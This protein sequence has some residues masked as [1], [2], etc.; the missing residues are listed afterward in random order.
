MRSNVFGGSIGNRKGHGDPPLCLK[1]LLCFGEGVWGKLRG[2][3]EKER[4]GGDVRRPARL[5]RDH[6]MRVAEEVES[7]KE[8][9]R[10]LDIYQRR[11]P[12]WEAEHWGEIF[13]E[14]RSWG[15]LSHAARASR[16]VQIRHLH[17][18]TR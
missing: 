2:V 9:R 7:L 16:N 8:D 6:T 11:I 12:W 17:C 15:E 13:D 1:K 5:K 3:V 14:R 4:W 18:M 10:C